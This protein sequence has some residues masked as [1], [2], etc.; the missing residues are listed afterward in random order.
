MIEPTTHE[1]F[2][3]SGP[4]ET[5]SRNGHAVGRTRVAIT[6]TT[7]SSNGH[8]P[9]QVRGTGTIRA[10][11]ITSERPPLKSG[12]AESIGRLSEGLRARGHAVDLLTGA[13]ARSLTI[14]E[15][16]FNSLASRWPAIGQT[17]SRYDIVNVH[18]PAPTISDAYL[19]LLR[20]VPRARRPH[21]VYTHHFSV[22][23]PGWR[24]ASRAYDRMHRLLTRTAD[25]IVVTSKSYESIMT[26]RHGPPVDV[27]P[28]GVDLERFRDRRPPVPFDGSRPLRL[29]FVGQM[30]QYK[31]LAQ[32]LTA[33]AG[34]PQLQLTLV[35]GGRLESQYRQLTTQSNVSFA[36]HVPDDS[37]TE[38]YL[39]HDVVVMPSTS[40]LE[41]FG[42]ALLEGMAAGCVP[43]ASDLPGVR[44][45]AGAT[46]R[47]VR[48]GDAADLRN[49][50]LALVAEPGMVRQLQLCSRSRAQRYTWEAAITAYE[51]SFRNAA[52]HTN[53][54]SKPRW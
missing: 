10:L 46:G 37:L 35:G 13:D 31:G 29:L 25:R 39:E 54:V 5:P 45:V 33:V 9:R 19:A 20:T 32:L 8:T 40:R 21:V 18:G 11:L 7:L 15:F 53:G 1:E 41:A 43:V 24:Q 23:L 4:D 47:T 44:D 30:R 3:R 27:I 14:G 16:R 38:L 2:A 50:L 12:V 28:W 26:T 17:L 36:G 48:V 51:G 34:Q 49:T 42:L 22:D 6:E 52:V